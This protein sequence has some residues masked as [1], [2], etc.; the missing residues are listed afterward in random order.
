MIVK[1]LLLFSAPVGGI[2]I[3]QSQEL[4]IDTKTYLSGRSGWERQ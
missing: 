4:T 3:W 2:L 1:R